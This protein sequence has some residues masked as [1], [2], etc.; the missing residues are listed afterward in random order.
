MINLTNYLRNIKLQKRFYD[1]IELLSTIDCSIFAEKYSDDDIKEGNKLIKSFEKE[2]DEILSIIINYNNSIENN[3]L[4]DKNYNNENKKEFKKKE[5]EELNDNGYKIIR[6]KLYWK[7]ENEIIQ[8]EI[9]HLLLNLQKI[10]KNFEDLEKK[11]KELSLEIINIS[12]DNE[13]SEKLLETC[14]YNRN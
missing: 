9:F 12:N 1:N 3:K 6:K 4:H 13:K 14:I 2:K 11:L 7:K 5:I 10:F 8:K